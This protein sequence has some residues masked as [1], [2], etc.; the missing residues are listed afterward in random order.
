MS[1][2]GPQTSPHSRVSARDG[3]VSKPYVVFW[4][5]IPAP[6]M[7][8]RFNAL[9]ARGHLDFEAWFSDRLHTDRSWTVEENAW[10]FRYRYL[11]S[12]PFS[13]D[14]FKLPPYFRGKRPDL[15]ITLHGKPSFVAGW[16]VARMLRIPI[17]FRYLMT[18]DAWFPRKWWKERLKRFMF[19]RVEA[20]LSPGEQSAANARRYG[21]PPARALILPQAVDVQHFRVA[22][23]LDDAKRRHRRKALGL[24]G[25]T[26]IYVGRLR[27]GKGLEYLVD[28]FAALQ[29]E[30]DTPTSLILVG[31]GDKEGPLREQ[32]QK[33]GAENVVFTGFI[34]RAELVHYYA[35]ADVF[36]FPTLGDPYGQVVNEAMACSLPIIATRA[37]GDITARVDNG[38]NGFVIAPEDSQELRKAMKILTDDADRRHRMGKLSA[39]KIAGQTPEQWAERFEQH[40]EHILAMPRAGA[41]KVS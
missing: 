12:I 17:A 41:R 39:R 3:I 24:E 6:Y 25:T 38:V 10:V 18:F 31:D 14:R 16:A 5:N 11:R 35:V 19:R 32:C 30:T 26:F 33:L 34:Q 22:S 13:K 27:K 9:A 40:V 15:I 7:V 28:A 21:V 29:Q 23:E 36:V 2:A 4:N 20:T 1:E 8:E 37:A